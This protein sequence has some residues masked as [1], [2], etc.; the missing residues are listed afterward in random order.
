MKLFKLSRNAV[1]ALYT[2]RPHSD[3]RHLLPPATT[4]PLTSFTSNH[5]SHG[6][7]L[8]PL[9][10][11]SPCIRLLLLPDPPFNDPYHDVQGRPVISS[12]HG[13]SAADLV[14]VSHSMGSMVAP[15]FFVKCKSQDTY[16]A[17]RA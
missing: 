6:H 1:R 3:S 14:I 13:Q 16:S 8:S 5:L 10:F 9:P 2:S 11:R 17:L 4:H 12:P 7:D 15:T